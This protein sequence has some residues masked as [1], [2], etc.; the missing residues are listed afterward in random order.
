MDIYLNK[1]RNSGI[2]EFEIGYDYI[3]VKFKNNSVYTYDNNSSGK[4]NI[5]KMK[6]LALSG[7]GLNTFINKHMRDKYVK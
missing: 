6:K 1:R 2:L 4:E 3:N 5:E 7:E